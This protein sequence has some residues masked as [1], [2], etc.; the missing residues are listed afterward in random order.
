MIR[1]FDLNQICNDF[2]LL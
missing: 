1:D 2:D